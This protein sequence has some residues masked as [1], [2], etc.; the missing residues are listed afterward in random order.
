MQVKEPQM[1]LRCS[2]TVLAVASTLCVG[3]PTDVAWTQGAGGARGRAGDR[4]AGVVLVQG[5]R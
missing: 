1:M 3:A 5:S 4:G 2:M